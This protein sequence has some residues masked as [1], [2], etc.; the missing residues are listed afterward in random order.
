MKSLIIKTRRDITC[1]LCGHPIPAGS[2]CRMIVDEENRHVYF[3]HLICPHGVPV[4]VFVLPFIPS[5]AAEM[6]P[7][8]KLCV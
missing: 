5:L 3:E 8:P 6:L 4:L 2:A 7:Q 1:D